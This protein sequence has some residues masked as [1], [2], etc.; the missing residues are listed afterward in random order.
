[1]FVCMCAYIYIYMCVYVCACRCVR[2]N[3][4]KCNPHVHLNVWCIKCYYHVAEVMVIDGRTGKQVKFL[5]QNAPNSACLVHTFIYIHYTSA[6]D[7]SIDRFFFFFFFFFS[8]YE[9]FRQGL[10]EKMG[11]INLR[12]KMD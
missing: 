3:V 6:H 7:I 4:I 5:F 1:M 10:W 9:T 2:V 11:Q 8:F 12:K